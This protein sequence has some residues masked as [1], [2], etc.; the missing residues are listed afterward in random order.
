MLPFALL[1]LVSLLLLFRF[2]NGG[3]EAD[4][5]PQVQC[6]QGAAAIQVKEGETCWEIGKA[7]GLGVEELLALTGNEGVECEKLRP[8]QSICVPA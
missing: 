3:S 5:G 6:G 8:G 1:V 4:D 7:H 2:I